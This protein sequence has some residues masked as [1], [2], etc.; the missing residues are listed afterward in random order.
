MKD[1]VSR[2]TLL[3]GRSG[4]DGQDDVI[5][6]PWS[7]PMDDFTKKCTGCAL[8]VQVC[9]EHILHLDDRNLARVDFQK[10]ECTF[11]ME[12]VTSCKDG[13]LISTDPDAPWALDI[14]IEGKCLA[15]KGVECRI[16]NDQCEPRAIRF[17]LTP[18]GVPLPQLDESACTGCG[19]CVAP[20][21]VDA[22][23]LLPE[24][25]KRGGL[26]G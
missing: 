24:N 6:P 8:C 16:C 25:Q 10:G 18:G 15:M 23:V 1:D 11:C 5:R 26:K 20:C 21:P 2:R 4:I 22:I 14:S 17:R 3:F 7:V 13:A 9:P 12:C 19:A